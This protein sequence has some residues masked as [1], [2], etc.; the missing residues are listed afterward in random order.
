MDLMNSSAQMSMQMSAM[1]TQN[2]YNI[3]LMKRTMEDAETQA[4]TLIDEMLEAVPVAA[5]PSEYNFDVRV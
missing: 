3:S 1:K 2:Q 4:T 5:A